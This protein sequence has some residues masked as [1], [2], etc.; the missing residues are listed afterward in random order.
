M[1]FLTDIYVT[2]AMTVIKIIV[3][4]YEYLTIPVYYLFRKTNYFMTFPEDEDSCY[5]KFNAADSRTLSMPVRE[6]DPGSPWRAVEYIDNLVTDA[7]PGC[8]T[9]PDLWLRTVKLWP[10]KLA[11]GTRQVLGTD[12]E[13]LPNGKK[14]VKQTMGDY[15]WE[16]YLEAEQRVSQLAAGIR[17]FL[18]PNTADQTPLVIF[19]ETRC[20]W[21]YAA[22]AAFRLNRPLATLY[23]TLGDEAVAHGLHQTQARVIFTSDELLSRVVKVVK[24]SPNVKYVIYFSNGVFQ[25]QLGLKVDDMSRFSDTARKSV[26]EGLKSAPEHVKI[27]D[28]LEMEEHGKKVIDEAPTSCTGD[29]NKPYFNWQPPAAERAKPEDLAVIMYT[30][31]STGQPKGVEIMHRNLNSAIGGYF[32]RMPKLRPDSDIYIGYL[33]QAHVLELVCEICVLIMG[34]PI[35]YS[36]PQTL[37]DTST[38]IKQDTCKGDLS[39]LRPTL[40]ASVPTV[41]DRI[42]KA[43]WEKVKEG[44]PLMEAIFRFAYNYKWRR[45]TTGFPSIIVDL[46]IFRKVRGL[47]GGR[48][49][50]MVSGGAPL[51]EESHLFT[52]VCF[53]PLIQG[54]GLTETCAAACLME[55]GDLRGHHVG[56]P[57]PSVQIKL[58]EWVDG[59]YSP[60]DKPSP[61]GEILISG[62]PVTR[63]YYK[64]P[65]ATAEAFITEPDGTRWF[66]TG[67]IG[68]VHQ[69]GSFSIIDRKKDLVKLQAGEYVSLVKVEL[70]IAQSAYVENVCVYADPNHDFTICFVSPK[71]SQIRKLAVELGLLEDVSRQVQETLPADRLKDESAVTLAEHQLLCKI[72]QIADIVL[73][74]IQDVGRAKKLAS[75]EI[76]RKL[77]LDADPWT[78]ESGLVTEALKIKRHNMRPKF[79]K[80]IEEMYGIQKRA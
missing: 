58:R 63:G 10:N 35:G 18:G 12:Y 69:D 78:P 79:L 20:E 68:M 65:E 38:R 32:R 1:S 80:D 49:R 8:K 13:V 39:V 21:L 70:A 64:N 45:L 51:S 25:K 77:V 9:L 52:N 67:D 17:D 2:V 15:F 16:T 61:R 29:I 26:E 11:L 60:H 46:L 5:Q 54:Y 71:I 27:F 56:A 41:L 50:C 37:T 30:S 44:G 4:S 74:D 72:K 34:I 3:Y 33:P 76:P 42:A 59:G 40:F 43:V 31:G 7:L 14:I 36:S 22:Q 6:G 57:T 24:S 75:F 47:I 53:A 19:S 23:A 48:V 55:S 28:I 73:K 62:S 66:C